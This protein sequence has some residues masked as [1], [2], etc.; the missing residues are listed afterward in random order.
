MYIVVILEVSIDIFNI[1]MVLGGIFFFFF[2]FFIFM[3][4]GI[5]VMLEISG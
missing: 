5:S 1:L 3:I 2:F 4:L